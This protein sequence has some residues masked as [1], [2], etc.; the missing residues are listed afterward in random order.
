VTLVL[1]VPAT[2][3]WFLNKP[4]PSLHPL[5]DRI[6]EEGAIVPY[7]WSLEVANVFQ[8]A[9]RRGRT[10][11]EDRD[12]AFSL[13]RLLPIAVDHAD[14]EVIWNAVLALSDMHGLT[15]YDAS[16]LELALRRQLPLATLDNNL[17]KAA[18]A[19]GLTVLP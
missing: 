1:D 11:G 15:S 14:R 9:I 10:S 13:M 7:F 3:A 4:G 6:V 5:T 19:E 16:Y 18:R 8:A 12:A 17:A 2:M